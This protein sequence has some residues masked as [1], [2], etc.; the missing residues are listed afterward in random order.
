MKDIR[1][2]IGGTVSHL[3]EAGEINHSLNLTGQMKKNRSC[4]MAA[5]GEAAQQVWKQDG[6]PVTD[7]S[8]VLF[9]HKLDGTLCQVN[10]VFFLIIVVL[11]RSRMMMSSILQELVKRV[12]AFVYCLIADENV[13][14]IFGSKFVTKFEE[15]GKTLLVKIVP[16]GEK[17]KSRKMKDEIEDFMLQVEINP[18]RSV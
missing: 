10:F 7:D 11:S 6:I 3:G 15:T 14:S 18:S 1:V 12:P 9:S 17:T 5:K 13:Y 4:Q 8:I 2:R 16:S